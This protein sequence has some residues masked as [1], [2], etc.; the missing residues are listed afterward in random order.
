MDTAS[1]LLPP[2]NPEEITMFW[3]NHIFW[4]APAPM[5]APMARAFI[6]VALLISLLAVAGFF[7]FDGVQRLLFVLAFTAM[8]ISN[9][10][11]AIGSLQGDARQGERL[12][13]AS[14]PFGV[15]MLIA[16]PL[17]AWLEYFA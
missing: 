15:V 17:V 3:L 10:L 2:G 7:L 9:L 4:S 16:L 12:R 11:W 13:A 14:R 1:R 6:V 8:S 5:P